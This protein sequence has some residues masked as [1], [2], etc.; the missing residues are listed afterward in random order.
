[1][2]TGDMFTTLQDY[3]GEVSLFIPFN[4]CSV[5]CDFCYNKGEW[6]AEN[7][8]VEDVIDELKVRS[9]FATAITLGGG[10]PCEQIDDLIAISKYAHKKGLKVQLQTSLVYPKA[11]RK[12]INKGHVDLIAGTINNLIFGSEEHKNNVI[13]S[14]AEI[15]KNPNIKLELKII[16]ISQSFT[17]IMRIAETVQGLNCDQITAQQFQATKVS[18]P[19]YFRV[20][21][22]DHQT[23]VEVGNILSRNN[24]RAVIG[25]ITVEQGYEVIKN[26]KY[27]RT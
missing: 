8:K 10:E 25:I 2:L 7:R 4:S 21:I 1:M 15:S 12:L 26:E 5:G 9:E 23:M 14:L 3:P 6:N 19:K 22:P 18:N 13:L 27:R 20:G 17:P 11:I 24:P 16:Y